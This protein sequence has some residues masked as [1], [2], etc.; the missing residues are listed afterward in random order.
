[1][2]MRG[3]YG[4][5]VMRPDAFGKRPGLYVVHG[6]QAVKVGNFASEEKAS[7]FV[8]YLGYLSGMSGKPGEDK[9]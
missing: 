4:L 9:E 3:E 8:E 2:M 5:E 6:N 7:A 1:M